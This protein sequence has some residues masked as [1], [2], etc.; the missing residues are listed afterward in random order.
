[1][2]TH[3][4]DTQSALRCA[5]LTP[6]PLCLASPLARPARDTHA[7][8]SPYVARHTLRPYTTPPALR[9]ATPCHALR[10]TL[11][12]VMVGCLIAWCILA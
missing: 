8:A 4:H 3:P 7:L 10:D 5:T 11:L 2:H 6:D 12:C 9:D 1:M